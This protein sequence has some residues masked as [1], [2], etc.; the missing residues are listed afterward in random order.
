MNTNVQT[1]ES[2]DP[3]AQAEDDL[4]E[5]YA[6][7][8]DVLIQLART[9]I[10]EFIMYVMRDEDTN[11]F[12]EQANTHRKMQSACDRHRRLILWSHV[13]AGKTFQIAVAR[14]LW[15]LGKNPSARVAIISNTADQANKIIRGVAKYIE[16]SVEYREVFPSVQQGSPWT[17]KQLHLVRPDG[18]IIRDPSVQACGVHGNI[19]GSRI[20][21]MIWDD[22]LD[23][24]NTH[25]PAT[26]EDTYNWLKSAAVLGRLL[27][28]A[29]VWCI[30]NAFHPDD[31]LHRFSREGRWKFLRLPVLDE[32]GRST[33]PERWPM[34]RIDEQRVDLGP[35]EFA[36][37]MLCRARSDSEARFK[38]DDLEACC[39]RGVGLSFAHSLHDLLASPWH[40][41]AGALAA[42]PL[43]P[44]GGGGDDA[45]YGAH[46]DAL[47]DAPA[48]TDGHQGQG[49]TDTD[50]E[51]FAEGGGPA[52]APAV[53]PVAR[54]L[55]GHA[56][57]RARAGDAL[58]RRTAAP[59]TPGVPGTD[60]A[61][62]FPDY[63]LLERALRVPESVRPT[64][65]PAPTDELPAWLARRQ[66]KEAE[67][68]MREVRKGSKRGASSPS[69]A[70]AAPTRGLPPGLPH[71][72]PQTT[73]QR[74]H[75]TG[76]PDDADPS[77]TPARTADPR[78]TVHTDHPHES[79]ALAHL[80]SA[81]P[82]PDTNADT[83]HREGEGGLIP[84]GEGGVLVQAGPTRGEKSSQTRQTSPSTVSMLVPGAPLGVRVAADAAEWVGRWLAYPG[85]P[86]RNGDGYPV[87]P[88]SAAGL[89]RMGVR[90]YTGV[91]L[92]VQRHSAA[93]YTVL[94]TIAVYPPD[95]EHGHE[96]RRVCE[97]QRGRWYAMDICKKIVSAHQRFGST[98]VLENVAAQDYIRQ[99]I[100]G[101]VGWDN[102]ADVASNVNE[103][104]VGYTTGRQKANPEFGIEHLAA[105]FAREQWVFPVGSTWEP[106]SNDLA[107]EL[108]QLFNEILYFDPREHTGDCLMSLW[109]AKEG[110]R[111]ATLRDAPARDMGMRTF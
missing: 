10:N 110:H 87:H 44:R 50:G 14:T 12:V 109:L 57:T 83:D 23:P 3:R 55:P 52:H 5:A 25:T 1:H 21:H 13:E 15:I 59:Q 66:V 46:G 88:R 103:W 75:S 98:V 90:F 16:N 19:Q 92:A 41:P 96:V 76:Q 97:I 105:E 49:S 107:D 22:I 38:R 17:S 106:G 39:A 104:L 11:A 93:D 42:R 30:G 95:G 45:E 77:G 54:P 101:G 27:A 29:P 47:L 26:R 36:R 37:Q 18:R 99:M 8:K 94:T 85:T 81:N 9:D 80:L 68:G 108:E 61:A 31:A 53:G 91:D 28:D 34:A 100:V 84:D 20:T 32:R 62:V 7:A 48:D 6:S 58:R 40:L 56:S 72:A 43:D 70:F 111:L 86:H 102:E 79:P 51:Q 2:V 67:F 73:A 35:L 74:A 69:R 82:S 71:A 89:S 60:P 78:T 4:R 33:W 63:D 65:L 24:E 64:P